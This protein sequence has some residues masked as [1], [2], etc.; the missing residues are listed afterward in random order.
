MRVLCSEKNI[1]KVLKRICPRTKNAINHWSFSIFLFSLFYMVINYTLSTHALR[2]IYGLM[3]IYGLSY[4]YIWAILCLYIYIFLFFMFVLAKEQNLDQN[5]TITQPSKQ[6]RY[7]A[8]KLQLRTN[9]GNA[10]FPM[11]QENTLRIQSNL[12]LARGVFFCRSSAR[13]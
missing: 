13:V 8:D 1:L 5:V 4:V 3:F 9:K 12:P 10:T 11:R 7:M 6:S 2:L